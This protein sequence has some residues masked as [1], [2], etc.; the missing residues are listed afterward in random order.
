MSGTLDGKVAVVTGA[1]SGIGLAI[2]QRFAAEGATLFITGRRPDAL[3]AAVAQIEG[4]VIGVRADA[5]SVADL[6]TLFA[7]VRER[8]GR[9]DAL[10]ANAGGGSF[11]PLGQI[12]EKHYDETFDANVKGTLFTVQGALPLLTDGASVVLMSSTTSVLGGKAFS[13]Y[14][15]SKAAVRNFARSWALD[16]ADRHIRVNALSPGPTRTPG[17]LGLVP[18][19][20]HS[21][22]LDS[23]AGDVPLGRV[24]DPAEIAG[25]ALFLVSPDASFVN[26]TELFADGGQAQV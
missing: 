12:T 16:L 26:G 9:I 3:E 23:L 19:D 13:V 2:A 5:A 15:A 7:T 6:D 10:V 22:L 8:A 25:A 24:A 11:L 18:D 4:E 20:Q 21:G 17:L 14:A 1:T